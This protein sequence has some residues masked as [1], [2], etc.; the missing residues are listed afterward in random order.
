[1]FN[2][3]KRRIYE[4]ILEI[5]YKFRYCFVVEVLPR[6]LQMIRSFSAEYVISEALIITSHI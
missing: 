6:F 3:K 5:V 1:M 2:I 4:S